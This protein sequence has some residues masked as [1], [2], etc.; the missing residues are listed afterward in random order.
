VAL[1]RARAGQ[2]KGGRVPPFVVIKPAQW[3]EKLAGAPQ[4]QGKLSGSRLYNER[5]FFGRSVA[6]LVDRIACP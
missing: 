1:I 2:N 3:R 5:S 4:T 6:R